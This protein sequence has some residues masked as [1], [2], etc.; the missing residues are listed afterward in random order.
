MNDCREKLLALEKSALVNALAKIAARPQTA[1]DVIERLL[2]TPDEN[3]DRAKR[4]VADL[5]VNDRY[6]DWREAPTFALELEGAVESISE[7]A[8]SPEEGIELLVDF[9]EADREAIERV[10]DSDGAIGAVFRIDATHAFVAF[11]QQCED[12]EWLADRVLQLVAGDG[13]GLRDDLLDHARAMFPQASLRAMADRLWATAEEIPSKDR[14][15]DYRR[16][17]CYGGVKTLARQLGDAPLYEKAMR[18]AWHGLDGALPLDVAQVYLET[19]DADAALRLVD[20]AAVG[21][22]YVSEKDGLLYTIYERQKNRAAWEEVAWRIFRRERSGATF[23]KLLHA[24][25]TK[26]RNTVLRQERK[27]ILEDA[28]LSYADAAFLVETGCLDDAA[29]YILKHRERLDGER[30]YQL[31]PLAEALENGGYPLAAT[32]CYRALTDSILGRAVSRYYH[33]GVRYLKRLDAL[34]PAITDWQEFPSHRPYV[35]SLVDAHKRKRSF[36]AQYGG[37]PSV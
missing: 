11:G 6:Y 22:R 8:A 21:A 30:Y 14:G 37:M 10:D 15:A 20:S 27:A 9:F 31:V 17:Q 19:G 12:K 18:A 16:R 3:R 4:V 7:S 24:I 2:S 1:E 23:E 5:R 26:R 13:Y 28:R 36:W 33:H 32:V 29:Q 34:A 35:K 25:G